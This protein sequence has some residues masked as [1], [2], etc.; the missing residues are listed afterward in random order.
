MRLPWS[1]SAAAIAFLALAPVASALTLQTSP[2]PAAD[3]GQVPDPHD[4]RQNL[5]G[6]PAEDNGVTTKIG[7]ATL[8]FGMSQR[9]GGDFGGNNWFL[10]S[11]A[12]R[13]VPSQAQ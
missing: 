3:D 8:H 11:P 2:P 6:Q 9:N 10:D 7:G 1:L 4:V 12:S 5:R 13:T